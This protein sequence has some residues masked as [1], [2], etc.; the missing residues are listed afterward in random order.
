VEQSIRGPISKRQLERSP[1]AP[2][3]HTYGRDGAR[4]RGFQQTVERRR[5]GVGGSRLPPG[6]FGERLRRDAPTHAVPDTEILI[7][8]HAQL[9]R[10]SLA[11]AAWLNAVHGVD[12]STTSWQEQE[13]IERKWTSTFPIGVAAA[14]RESRAGRKPA[15]A[16]ESNLLD[17]AT[18][19]PSAGCRAASGL[20]PAAPPS[21]PQQIQL[22]PATLETFGEAELADLDDRTIHVLRMRSG[23]LDGEPHSFE[24]TPNNRISHERGFGK[25][26]TRGSR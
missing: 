4:G 2:V 8:A 3:G 23:I 14:R 22:P 24:E 21:M 13:P 26:K 6:L 25:Y 1:G 16:P 9:G 17:P 18:S 20:T 15:V 7:N 11:I 5:R 12:C 19:P 10:L